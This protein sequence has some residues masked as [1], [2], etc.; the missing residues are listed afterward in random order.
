MSQTLAATTAAMAIEITRAKAI[1]FVHF[2]LVTLP[3]RA[4]SAFDGRSTHSIDGDQQF[5]RRL[6]VGFMLVRTAHPIASAM[7]E[8]STKEPP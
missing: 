2:Q 7:G 4:F 3:G 5:A 1:G 6:H 8:P